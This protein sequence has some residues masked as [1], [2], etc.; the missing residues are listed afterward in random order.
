MIMTSFESDIRNGLI[1]A[2]G[3]SP[4]WAATIETPQ[5]ISIIASIVLPCIFFTVGKYI[6]YKLQLRR[7]RQDEA[8]K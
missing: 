7:E 3:S 5:L 8:E 6:D 2:I 4:V 1:S